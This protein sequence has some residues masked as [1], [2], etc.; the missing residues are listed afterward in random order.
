MTVAYT[1][2]VL[3]VILSA[4]VVKIRMINKIIIVINGSRRCNTSE[5]IE[6]GI[7]KK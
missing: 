5:K 1:K 2:E 6:R 3:F 4:E 7:L